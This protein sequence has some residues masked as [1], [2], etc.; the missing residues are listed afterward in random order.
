MSS[1]FVHIREVG[2]RVVVTANGIRPGMRHSQQILR[3]SHERTG[4]FGLEELLVDAVLAVL[5]H[6]EAQ[7]PHDY[8]L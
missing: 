7:H 2:D 1:V 5:R 6:M 8:E 3:I 4:P